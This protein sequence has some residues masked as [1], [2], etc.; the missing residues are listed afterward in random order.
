LDIDKPGEIQGAP[1]D[2]ISGTV[3]DE[4]H[5]KLFAYNYMQMVCFDTSGTEWVSV[6][7]FDADMVGVKFIDNRVVC[8]GP[9]DWIDRDRQFEIHLDPDT[10]KIVGGDSEA[11][12]VYTKP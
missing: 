7:L 3:S 11:V 10:G 4:R 5:R 2:L 9:M 8:N 1:I 6:G 12:A